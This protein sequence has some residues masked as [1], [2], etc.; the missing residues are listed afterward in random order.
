MDNTQ[1]NE[2]RIKS[3]DKGWGEGSVIFRTYQAGNV[4]CPLFYVDEIKEEFKQVN[5]DLVITVY[6]GYLNGK[7]KFEMGASIDVTVVYY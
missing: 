1:E 7:L 4:I 6:R 3:I 5:S 2:P